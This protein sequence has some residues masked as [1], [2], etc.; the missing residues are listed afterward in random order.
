MKQLSELNPQTTK[1]I[2]ADIQ[3]LTQIIM[4]LPH[5]R[6]EQITEA[7][8]AIE[9]T[10]FLYS[11]SFPT[12]SR[13]FYLQGKLLDL[14][15]EQTQALTFYTS[16]IALPK[17]GIDAYAACARLLCELGFYEKSLFIIDEVIKKQHDLLDTKTLADVKEFKEKVETLYDRQRLNNFRAQN[18]SRFMV[19]KEEKAMR[20]EVLLGIKEDK[21]CQPKL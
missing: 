11:L 15:G 8:D 3:S 9:R 16:A 4:A 10:L 2:D 19:Y 5:A 7:V 18:P 1:D 17:P 13:I 14:L 6:R 12:D 21:P 20:R